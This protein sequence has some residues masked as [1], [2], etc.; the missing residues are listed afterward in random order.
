MLTHI[1]KFTKPE[2]KKSTWPWQSGYQSKKP[3]EIPW[4]QNIGSAPRKLGK[5][6]YANHIKNIPHKV[7]DIVIFHSRINK[8]GDIDTY[9]LIPSAVYVVKSIQE[10][11]GFVDY[12]SA[13]I[14][15]CLCLI[16]ADNGGEFWTTADSWKII[17]VEILPKSIKDVIKRESPVAYAHSYNSFHKTTAE[18]CEPD[19][20]G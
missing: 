4:F 1:I 6:E 13:G 2:S 3:P 14:P 10:M 12:D 15:K 19:P 11:H 16:P 7:N 17:D 9:N 5:L 8:N 18:D 20:V